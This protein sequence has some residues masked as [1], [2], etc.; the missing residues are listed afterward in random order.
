MNS[1]P[2]KINLEYINCP[3]KCSAE[4][5]LVLSGNDLL[6]NLPGLFH[7]Y[8][9]KNCGL[10][11][12]SPR[13]SDDSIGFYYPESYGPYSDIPFLPLRAYGLKG[14]LF[15]FLGLESRKLPNVTPSRMLELGCSSGAY[16]E[17]ARSIGWDVQ[18]IE[19]SPK[20]A[21]L[22]IKKGFKVH[23]GSVENASYEKEQFDIIVAWMVMEHL[24][25]P[26]LVLTKCLNWLKKDGY[27]VF[28][29]PNRDSISRKLFGSLSFD[30]QL[31][32]HLFHYNE[33]SLKIL[34][35]NFGWEIIKIKHQSNCNTF[36][37]SIENW[38]IF[39]KKSGLLKYVKAFNNSNKTRWIRL[40]LAVIFGKLKQS[41][42]IEVWAKPIIN[43]E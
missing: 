4:S 9:C 25:Y 6:H 36:L 7:I 29:V 38:C 5:D 15:D 21:N 28:L 37:K 20:A 43:N 35:H 33:K 12:T 13:P 2:K 24:H 27:L 3:N 40:I 16:M 8:R 31:P 41:G 30:T 34:L 19:F 39:H 23:I 18:G 32:T 10:E 1:I 11:R 22:A 26:E 17:Y 14:K 42:R